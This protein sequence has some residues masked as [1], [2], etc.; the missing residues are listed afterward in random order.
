MGCNSHKSINDCSSMTLLTLL[1]LAPYSYQ[2]ARIPITHISPNSPNSKLRSAWKSSSEPKVCP[3]HWAAVSS[4]RSLDPP[5]RLS[6]LFCKNTLRFN[7]TKLVRLGFLLLCKRG[8]QQGKTG[9]KCDRGL[10]L[11]GSDMQK[12]PFLNLMSD[13]GEVHIWEYYPWGIDTQRKQGGEGR[14]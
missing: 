7:F 14:K 12:G 5:Y 4:F 3:N 13:H 8:C 6:P 11:F 10:L 1:H 2:P 9:Y